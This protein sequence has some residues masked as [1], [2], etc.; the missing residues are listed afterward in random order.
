MKFP[1]EYNAQPLMLQVY[2]AL[3]NTDMLYGWG[4]SQLTDNQSRFVQTDQ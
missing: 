4:V 2:S 3:D 1:T